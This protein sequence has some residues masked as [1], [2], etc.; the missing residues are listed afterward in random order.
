MPV[1][2]REQLLAAIST[3]VSGEPGNVLPEDERTLPITLVD[4]DAES[5]TEDYDQVVAEMPV[6]VARAVVSTG[7]EAATQRAQAHEVLAALIAEMNADDTFGGL[8]QSTTYGV[9]GIAYNNKFVAAEAQFT[10]TYSYLRGD[11]YTAS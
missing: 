7:R 10:I 4:D 9:G 11:P 2:I 6:T 5:A 3:A 8:A 1:S